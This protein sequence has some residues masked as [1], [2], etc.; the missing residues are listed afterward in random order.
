MYTYDPPTGFTHET[1]HVTQTIWKGTKSV[2]C[3]FRNCQ[4]LFQSG[5][6]GV[7]QPL[8]LLSPHGCKR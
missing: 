2:G 5:Q 3:Q 4:G 6:W 1:G 7:R 8:F